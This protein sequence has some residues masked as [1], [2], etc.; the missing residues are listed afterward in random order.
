MADLAEDRA[1]ALCRHQEAL[2][3]AGDLCHRDVRSVD[4]HAHAR[5]VEKADRFLMSE[6]AEITA[7]CR[8]N[9]YLRQGE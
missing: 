3:V 7:R 9:E 4:R 1:A 8:R 2:R 5:A 6:L